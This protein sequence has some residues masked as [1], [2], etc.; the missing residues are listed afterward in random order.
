M[1]R[2]CSSAGYENFTRG[3]SQGMRT[4]GSTLTHEGILS[5]YDIQF[6][7]SSG[8]EADRSRGL[9]DPLVCP[10]FSCASSRNPLTGEG[11]YYLGVGIQ[12]C[13]SAEEL[14]RRR[15]PLCVVFVLDV[16]GAMANAYNFLADNGRLSKLDVAKQLVH[17]LAEDLLSAVD[18]YS[19]VTFRRSHD[20]KVPQDG[21]VVSLAELN[22]IEGFG[23]GSLEEAMVVAQAEMVELERRCIEQARDTQ[24]ATTMSGPFAC[25]PTGCGRSSS[26]SR[27]YVVFSDAAPYASNGRTQHASYEDPVYMPSSSFS[28]SSRYRP[29][30]TAEGNGFLSAVTAEAKKDSYTL[31]FGL[32]MSS[33][34]AEAWRSELRGIQGCN[35]AEVR[36]EIEEYKRALHREFATMITPIATD[37]SMEL[38][39]A[40]FTPNQVYGWQAP[41]QARL[42]ARE[43]EF[44]RLTSIFPMLEPKGGIYMLKLDPIDFGDASLEGTVG[45]AVRV[46]WQYRD[47][48][49]NVQRETRTFDFTKLFPWTAHA[50]PMTRGV[51]LALP[52]APA[53]G[54][55]GDVDIELKDDSTYS[56]VAIRKAVL[57][58][59]FVRFVHEACACM[60]V[61]ESL[62]KRF[63]AHWARE[64]RVI[65]DKALAKESNL[66]AKYAAQDKHMVQACVV[67]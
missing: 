18:G 19:I 43:G 26:V 6:D 28:P 42:H 50:V 62:L 9:G 15:H 49:H 40:P 36:G 44:L 5:A 51:Q 25:R 38:H 56:D 48:H 59:R 45:R 23:G 13:L 54:S 10:H 12:P 11:E 58:V 32:A 35:F 22:Q 34:D 7:E 66:L 63:Q 57:L 27:R 53:I 24:Q 16:S 29:S 17:F 8:A 46:S 20:S 2:L 52:L 37:F 67:L 14:I 65:G 61:D 30:V 3:L 31:M 41:P 4:F 47:I 1:S 39:A 21:N 60:W 64:Q 55:S 33:P